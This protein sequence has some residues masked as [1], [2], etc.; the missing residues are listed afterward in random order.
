MTWFTQNHPRFVVRNAFR[1]VFLTSLRGM[2]FT[3][4]GQCDL[5]AGTVLLCTRWDIERKAHGFFTTLDPHAFESKWVSPEEAQHPQYM[6]FVIRLD[7]A[8]L[9]ANCEAVGGWARRLIDDEEAVPHTIRFYSVADDFGFF[10]N[11]APYPISL[12]GKNWPTSEHYF[13]AQKFA[14]TEYEQEIRKAKTPMIAAHLGRDHSKPIRQDWERVKDNVMHEAV[15][16]KF[17]QHPDIRLR[18]LETADATLI[19]H[20][21]RDAYWGDGGDGRGKNMLGRILME[22]RDQLK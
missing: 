4:G 22:V 11:F 13:Q 1:A 15:Y 18:L 2:P 14:G 9:K 10:A 16:A 7:K 19:E 20:T 5:P 8:T 21:S 6:G 3:G 12:K 17:E